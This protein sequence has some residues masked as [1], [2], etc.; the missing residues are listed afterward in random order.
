M[1]CMC[2]YTHTHAYISGRKLT[3]WIPDPHWAVE[4]MEK[5]IV[6]AWANYGQWCT[7]K[8]LSENDVVSLSPFLFSPSF[9]TFSSSVSVR[10]R[11][12]T[13]HIVTNP[14]VCNAILGAVHIHHNIKVSNFWIRLL[15]HMFSQWP[16]AVGISCCGL[17]VCV[18]KQNVNKNHTNLIS[19]EKDAVIV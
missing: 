17:L 1:L 11:R 7:S 4:V 9:S 3:G 12:K 10:L 18:L 8:F 16:R 2:L 5:K 15:S 13:P 6:W 14:N 19:L